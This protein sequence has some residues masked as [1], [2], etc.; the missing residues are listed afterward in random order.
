MQRYKNEYVVY[1]IDLEVEDVFHLFVQCP[2]YADE[3]KHLYKK[4]VI[5]CFDLPKNDVELLML[6]KENN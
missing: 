5:L 2:L 1:Y 3:R 4:P 6:L